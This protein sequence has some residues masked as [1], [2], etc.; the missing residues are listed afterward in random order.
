MTNSGTSVG[1]DEADGRSV[2][3]SVAIIE[4]IE[5]GSTGA[6]L[7][8]VDGM[9]LSLG[10]LDSSLVGCDEIDGRNVGRGVGVLEGDKI[11]R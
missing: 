9:E 11:G 5:L 7:G 6:M 2:G 1:P 3:R 4:G 10:M 8:L